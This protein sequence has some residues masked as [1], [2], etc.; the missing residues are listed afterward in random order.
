MRR[1]MPTMPCRCATVLASFVTVAAAA[2][3]VRSCAL[4]GWNV[5]TRA[6]DPVAR[7]RAQ[8]LSVSVSVS[9][10][11]CARVVANAAIA[12]VIRLSV[13]HP[14]A[15]AL[16]LALIASY[17]ACAMAA[18]ECPRAPEASLRGGTLE[19]HAGRRQAPR[20]AYA[21]APSRMAN[22]GGKPSAV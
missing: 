19:R 17:C 11:C 2:V 7:A 10:R 12:I 21:R 20:G 6:G 8:L 3:Q 9:D 5:D 13:A 1:Q 15:L 14:V 4:T 18:A 22:T 16:P